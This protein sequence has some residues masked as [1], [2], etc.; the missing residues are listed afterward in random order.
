MPLSKL[1]LTAKTLIMLSA[2]GVA[3][4]WCLTST[5]D[6]MTRLDCQRGIAAAC[7]QVGR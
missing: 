2:L 5:L 1:W 3:A 7:K 6:D 4:F